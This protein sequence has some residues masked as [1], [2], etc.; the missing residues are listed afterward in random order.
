VVDFSC[1]PR[2]RALRAIF[3][4]VDTVMLRQ[5]YVLFFIDLQRRKV[6]WPV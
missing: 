3:F 1:E 6:F 4:D 2:L 5:V